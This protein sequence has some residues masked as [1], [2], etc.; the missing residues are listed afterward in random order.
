[1]QD[2]RGA[3]YQPPGAHPAAGATRRGQPLQRRGRGR[4]HTPGET[5]AATIVKMARILKYIY[6]FKSLLC[7]CSQT[8]SNR[9]QRFL[10]IFFDGIECVG[11][12]LAY[13][14]YLW[15]FIRHLDSNPECCHP[16]LSGAQR[17]LAFNWYICLLRDEQPGSYF[18]ELR[19]H[20][21]SFFLG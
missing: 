18:L 21:F 13:V 15:F 4:I 16:S 14:A 1:M 6:I 2:V 9:A 3:D 20:F 5:L 17:Y 8:V 7:L 12:S 11:H 10:C 19:N